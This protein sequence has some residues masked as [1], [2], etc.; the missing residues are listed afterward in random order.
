MVS[1]VTKPNIRLKLLLFTMYIIF[2]SISVY[3]HVEEE[4]V[5][6]EEINLD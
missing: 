6:A 3:S 2:L 1:K 4:E 5:H